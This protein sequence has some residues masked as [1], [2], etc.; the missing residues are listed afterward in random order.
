MKLGLESSGVKK[1]LAHSPAV[2]TDV[3]WPSFAGDWSVV[4]AVG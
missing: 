1:P 2:V 4:E 3:S